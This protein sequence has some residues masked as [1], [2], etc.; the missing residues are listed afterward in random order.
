MA[1]NRNVSSTA[2]ILMLTAGLLNPAFAQQMIELLATQ[3]KHQ[4]N[5]AKEAKKLTNEI[6][7]NNQHAQQHTLDQSSSHIEKHQLYNQ[8]H[9][10]RGHG[11]R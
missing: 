11:R 10:N 2:S 1:S 8:Q 9:A 7:K 3:E 4:K 6:F 5:Q